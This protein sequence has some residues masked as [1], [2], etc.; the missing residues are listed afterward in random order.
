MKNRARIVSLILAAVMILGIAGCNNGP[1]VPEKI[2]TVVVLPTEESTD[3]SFTPAAETPEVPTEIV[4]DLPADTPELNTTDEATGTVTDTSTAE[5]SDT[6]TAEPSD[7]P[8]AEPAVTPTI[9]PTVTP[10]KEPTATSTPEPTP[11][12][13]PTATPTKTPAATPTATP[14]P[15][16]T[17]TKTPTAAPTDPNKLSDADQARAEALLNSAKSAAPEIDN[18]AVTAANDDT[19]IT[20]WFNHSY[21]N[22]PAEDVT[23]TGFKAYQ[24]KLAKNEIEGCHFLVASTKAKTGLDVS[25]S[26]FS[27]GNGHTLDHE[28]CFGWYFDGVDGKTVADPIPVL[29]RKIDLKANRSQMFIIKVKSK[30]DTP[31]GQYSAVITI[32]DSEGREIKKANV[33]AYVWNFTLP[34]ASNCKTLSDLGEWPL[35]VGAGRAGTTQD[36]LEDDLYAQYYEYLLENKINCYTLPYAKRGQFW[37]DRVEQYLDDPR[38]NAFTL[39]WKIDRS[40]SMQSNNLWHEAYIEVAY[41]RLSKKQEWLDK[42][43]FYPYY[44][45][46]LNG[47]EPLTKTALDNIIKWNAQFTKYFG[48][49][50]LIIPIHYNTLL[51]TGVDFFKYLENDVTVWCPK[52]YFFNTQ[53]DKTFN[54]SLYTDFYGA[55]ME[56]TFGTFKDRMANEQAGGDEVWWYVT[57]FPHNPEITLSMNDESVKHR[58]MFWQQKLYN[59]DGFLYYQVNEWQGDDPKVWNKKYEYSAANTVVNTYGN[60]VLIYHGAGLPEYIEHYGNDGY[61]GGVGSLRL[62]S[63]RDGV[64]DYDYFTIL[65]E[66]YGDG[67]SDLIIKQITTS[68]GVYSTDTDLFTRLRTAV[69]DLIAAK[70]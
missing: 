36:G 22:T 39:F 15:A 67:T 40:T 1:A 46:K 11:T 5:P 20:V 48:K 45:D 61:P 21:I 54:K 44:D 14:T 41:N 8:T 43:Y 70:S 6:P 58:L 23:P 13:T 17:P 37:D 9:E 31:S 35:I 47:D 2:D 49:H 60:G 25:V 68:L 57:R 26:D 52:T 28:L 19:D 62:E 32:K 63:V 16:P 4:T 10:T 29:E 53:E 18:S 27:D 50:K 12:K 66:L 59:V 33:Y 24:I 65:D 55:S 64:E 34:V 42:A 30:A 56:K 3:I 69:G 51:S 38:M 7:T